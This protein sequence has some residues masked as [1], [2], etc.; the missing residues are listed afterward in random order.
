[1][2]QGPFL[3]FNQRTRLLGQIFQPLVVKNWRETLANLSSVWKP[4]LLCLLATTWSVYCKHACIHSGAVVPCTL[5][6]RQFP[7]MSAAYRRHS[8]LLCVLSAGRG[9]SARV[10]PLWQSSVSCFFCFF[11][12]RPLF[13]VGGSGNSDTI[14]LDHGTQHIAYLSCLSDDKIQMRLIQIDRETDRQTDRLTSFE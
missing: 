2:S 3:I 8:K 10:Q 9:R 1:M 4:H 5:N 12:V 11:F 7:W 6:V 13:A 14:C